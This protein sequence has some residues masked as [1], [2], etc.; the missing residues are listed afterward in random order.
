MSSAHLLFSSIES[1]YHDLDAVKYL[2]LFLP[3]RTHIVHYIK[4]RRKCQTIWGKHTSVFP[5]RIF[6]PRDEIFWHWYWDCPTQNM[7]LLIVEVKVSIDNSYGH[8]RASATCSR[9][10]VSLEVKHKEMTF[11]TH[12]CSSVLLW[13]QS[14]GL[15][16]KH[17]RVSIYFTADLH[18]SISVQAIVNFIIFNY[19]PNASRFLFAKVEQNSE[20]KYIY[21]KTNSE[22]HHFGQISTLLQLQYTVYK[23][24][25]LY[26]KLTL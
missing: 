5:M 13:N 20:S 3:A 9:L 22:M 25:L 17:W 10:I 1:L 2:F 16:L 26:V 21:N 14:T 19:D 11:S 8:D 6:L 24:N 12:H 4:E 23:H 7:L 15:S 18:S